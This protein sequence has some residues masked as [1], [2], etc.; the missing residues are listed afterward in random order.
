M[1]GTAKLTYSIDTIPSPL[2]V[3]NTA[4][5]RLIVSNPN[6]SVVVYVQSI[7]IGFHIGSAANQLTES[8]GSISVGGYDAHLWT[9]SPNEVVTNGTN[10]SCTFV[11]PTGAPNAITNQGWVFILGNI[12]VNSTDGTVIFTLSEKTSDATGGSSATANPPSINVAKDNTKYAITKFLVY[13]TSD[14]QKNQVEIVPPGTPISLDW[15]ATDNATYK[16]NS[17]QY[18]SM[19]MNASNNGTSDIGPANTPGM[20]TLTGKFTP[21]GENKQTFATTAPI[22]MAAPVIDPPF[23]MP[24]TPVFSGQQ[25]AVSFTANNVSTV[26]LR[27]A[28]ENASGWH[29]IATFDRPAESWT[30]TQTNFM[31]KP[32]ADIAGLQL[33]ANGPGGEVIQ[34]VPFSVTPT[35]QWNTASGVKNTSD[36]PQFT[37]PFTVDQYLVAVSGFQFSYGANAQKDFHEWEKIQ[38]K[39]QPTRSAKSSQDPPNSMVT[40]PITQV[41]NNQQNP[42]H[43]LDP[44]DSHVDL[45]VFAAP[46]DAPLWLQNVKTSSSAYQGPPGL[47]ISKDSF[48]GVVSQWSME[49]SDGDHHYISDI[50]Y[51]VTGNE[52]KNAGDGDEV[53]PSV[54]VNVVAMVKLDGHNVNSSSSLGLLATSVDGSGFGFDCMMISDGNVPNGACFTFP[55]E[56]DQFVLIIRNFDSGTSNDDYHNLQKVWASIS[57]L[58]GTISGNKV[59]CTGSVKARWTN[60]EQT[61]RGN[62]NV[63][64]VAL[65]KATTS[66]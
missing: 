46:A 27:Y 66:N 55:Q 8:S 48:E 32:D 23:A 37:F 53:P 19:D 34:E 20:F 49:S 15:E 58:N 5:L 14:S 54:K 39:L 11:A 40:V 45:V 42:D 43:P 47:I 38:L 1:T 31:F 62:V 24:T 56:V 25:A 6:P 28:T 63:M 33:V 4:Q 13:E 26:A 57:N 3:G 7:A 18:P 52:L 64:C 17:P 30:I 9:L 44:T 29:E 41:L 50:Q 65:Y 60:G 59:N 61:W 12:K 16:L 2:Q 51:Y 35:I 21:V 36:A 22:F 10:A